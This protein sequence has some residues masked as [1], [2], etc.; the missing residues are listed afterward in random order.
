M[1]SAFILFLFNIVLSLSLAFCASLIP[2]WDFSIHHMHVE[3]C[4]IIANEEKKTPQQ[5]NW[6]EHWNNKSGDDLNIKLRSTAWCSSSDTLDVCFCKSNTF[7]CAIE[8]G[9][10]KS[11]DDRFWWFADFIQIAFDKFEFNSPRHFYMNTRS[12]QRNCILYSIQSTLL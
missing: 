7:V 10:C 8:N 11:T 4:I 5:L 9:W 6:I 12:Q 3:S 2:A 1:F